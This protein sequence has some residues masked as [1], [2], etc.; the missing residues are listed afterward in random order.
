MSTHGANLC[1]AK[2]GVSLRYA[3]ET[4]VVTADDASGLLN[5]IIKLLLTLIS[6]VAYIG[7]S[8][9]HWS[10]ESAGA[11]RFS[12]IIV[13]GYSTLLNFNALTP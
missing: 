1:R 11:R 5:T 10:I 7:W 2:P 12:S 6:G 13:L 9:I 4:K 8:Q 3:N